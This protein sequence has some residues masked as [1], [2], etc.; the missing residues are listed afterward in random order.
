MVVAAAALVGCGSGGSSASLDKKISQFEGYAVTSCQP[1]SQVDQLGR[2]IGDAN[3]RAYDCSGG[4]GV[5][6]E[7]DGQMSDFD[8]SSD[9]HQS[10]SLTAA[11]VAAKIIDTVRNKNGSRLTR[12]DCGASTDVQSG[13]VL[14]CKITMPSGQVRP[15]TASV[16][17]SQGHFKVTLGVP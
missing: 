13:S 4:L 10:S 17:G 14:T 7:P 12:V 2:E 8:A 16:S 1:D 11:E 6:I 5:V 3:A 9:E 15:F